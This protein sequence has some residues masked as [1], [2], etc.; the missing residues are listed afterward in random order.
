MWASAC[1]A[2]LASFEASV[3]AAAT[4]IWE[5]RSTQPQENEIFDAAMTGL[6]ALGVSTPVGTSLMAGALI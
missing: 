1:L 6:F 4:G 5:S 3:E 2:I